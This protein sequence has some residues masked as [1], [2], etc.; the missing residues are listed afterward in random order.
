MKHLMEKK[1]HTPYARYANKASD[2]F[3]YCYR[4]NW[5]ARHSVTRQLSCWQNFHDD[6]SARHTLRLYDATEFVQRLLLNAFI[7]F[8]LTDRSDSVLFLSYGITKG[9]WL[10][11]SQLHIYVQGADSTLSNV[12]LVN[13]I[14]LAPWKAIK[15]NTTRISARDNVVNHSL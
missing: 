10:I 8:G 4:V 1:S 5:I 11:P 15:S 6:L 2:S 7:S 13:V 9:Q 14:L 12:R 3:E